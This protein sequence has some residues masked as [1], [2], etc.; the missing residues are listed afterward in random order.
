[1]LR[2][3]GIATVGPVYCGAHKQLTCLASSNTQHSTAAAARRYCSPCRPGCP[4]CRAAFTRRTWPM[5]PSLAPMLAQIASSMEPRTCRNAT[6]TELACSQV[7]VV[8]TY[9]RQQQQ[10]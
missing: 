10:E 6:F 4:Y 7:S 8:T 5:L 2:A 3:R 9:G 1:M